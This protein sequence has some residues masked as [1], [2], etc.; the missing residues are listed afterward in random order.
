MNLLEVACKK[1]APNKSL[2]KIV[3]DF[4]MVCDLELQIEITIQPFNKIGY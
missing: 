3:K 4:Y 2:K 1:S